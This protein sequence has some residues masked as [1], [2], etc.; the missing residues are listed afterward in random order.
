M[1]YMV[2]SPSSDSCVTAM[3]PSG[4]RSHALQTQNGPQCIRAGRFVASGRNRR[5]AQGTGGTVRRCKI[6]HPLTRAGELLS[7]REMA[8][9]NP[10]GA[11]QHTRGEVRSVRPT[12]P[13]T[14]G[15]LGIT[16][17][18]SVPI[19]LRQ[20]STTY[21]AARDLIWRQQC[22]MTSQKP[23]ELLP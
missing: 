22:A 7:E 12:E 18:Q 11:N 13:K 4:S 10:T 23:I 6:S 9:P 8:K 3:S 15:E 20:T 16:K 19:R 1:S 2:V 5:L 17:E 21:R 14:L